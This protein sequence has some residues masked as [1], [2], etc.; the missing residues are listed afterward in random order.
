MNY[1]IGDTVTSC[2][3]TLDKKELVFGNYILQMELISDKH[4]AILPKQAVKKQFL[5]RWQDLP[6]SVNNIDLA[7]K[8]TSYIASP[9]EVSKMESAKTQKEKLEN[10]LSFWKN[11][12]PS[13]EEYFARVDYANEKFKTRREGWKTDMGMVFIIFGTPDYIDRH[14]FELGSQPYEVWDYYTVNRRFI[15]V[16]ETGFGDYRSVYPIWDN[17]VRV[18]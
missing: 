10:F 6:I 7:I 2:F 9:S 8:Q 14:P 5:I 4:K 16:D 18:N 1:F 11:R 3:L 15:F 13:M 12:K 17:T